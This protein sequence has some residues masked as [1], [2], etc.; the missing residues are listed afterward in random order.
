MKY[1]LL[2]LLSI[3][4]NLGAQVK[5]KNLDSPEWCDELEDYLYLDYSNRIQVEGFQL[6]SLSF[7]K[8]DEFKFHTHKNN[9]FFLD[10]LYKGVSG[11]VSLYQKD[12]IIFNRSF[13]PLVNEMINGREIECQPSFNSKYLVFNETN[14]LQVNIYREDSFKLVSKEGICDIVEYNGRKDIY[15]IIPKRIGVDTLAVMSDGKVILEKEF[16]V[17]KI[18]LQ[19][20]EIGNGNRNCVYKGVKNYIDL[21]EFKNNPS[22]KFYINDTLHELD[23]NFQLIF[24]PS[25]NCNV[26]IEYAG[27]EIYEESLKVK[28]D[29]WPFLV[30]GDGDNEEFTFIDFVNEPLVRIAKPYREIAELVYFEVEI[31]VN[32]EK[33]TWKVIGENRIPDECLKLMSQIKGRINV[34]IRNAT[35]KSSKGKRI[36]PTRAFIIVN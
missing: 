30:F 3:H 21:G 27:E 2:V 19:N 17:S 28:V 31:E 1:V 5:L 8:I 32:D 24:V 7:I 6:D 15:N 14:F 35:I 10:T 13:I 18:D 11:E 26:K 12:S 23:E 20:Q 16:V 4:F 29:G 9:V 33:K 25:D 34:V 36:T 22:Y